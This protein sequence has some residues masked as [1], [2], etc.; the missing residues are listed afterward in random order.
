MTKHRVEQFLSEC[1]RWAS[2]R[3]DI[4]AV[5]LVGSHAR[6]TPA[7]TSDVDLVIVANRPSA[8]LDD[9]TWAEAFGTITNEQRE[10]YGKLTSLRIH[11]A[12]GLEVEFGLADETWVA[13]PLDPGTRHVLLGGVRVLFERRSHLTIRLEENRI[14]HVNGE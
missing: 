9:R 1:T 5:A 12:D 4:Q 13:H 3:E 10:N 2:R 8:Y 6:G 14:S 7:D 11:Y